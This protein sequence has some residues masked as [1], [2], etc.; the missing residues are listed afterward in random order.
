MV[1]CSGVIS[2]YLSGLKRSPTKTRLWGSGAFCARAIST[3]P[4]AK[5][6]KIRRHIVVLLLTVSRY[7]SYVTPNH[8]GSVAVGSAGAG[9]RTAASR[10]RPL[11][12]G[13]YGRLHKIGEDC[14]T[15]CVAAVQ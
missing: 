8:I 1:F 4:I 7:L 13:K 14:V 11:R 10:P 15:K 2:S 6:Q 12:A 5:I 3:R 9:I